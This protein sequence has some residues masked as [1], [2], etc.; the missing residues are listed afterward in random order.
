MPLAP[1]EQEARAN[2][3]GEGERVL[4][5]GAPAATVVNTSPNERPSR[6]SIVAR[7][8]VITGSGCVRHTALDSTELAGATLHHGAGAGGPCRFQPGRVP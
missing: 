2:V 3:D 1:T 6:R 5:P 7:L 8:A 4:E